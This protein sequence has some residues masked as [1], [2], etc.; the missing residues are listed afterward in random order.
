M[1]TDLPPRRK[2]LP[3]RKM[4]L[5]QRTR[6]GTLFFAAAVV[7]MIAI[8]VVIVVQGEHDDAVNIEASSQA[9]TY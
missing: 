5:P 2:A 6:E 7:L 1:P 9:A 3:P 8:S 4:T